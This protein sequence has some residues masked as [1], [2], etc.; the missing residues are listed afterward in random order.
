M[1]LSGVALDDY[2]SYRSVVVDLTPG[3]SVLLGRNG[4]GKT[5]FLEAIGY[6]STLHSHRVSADTALIRFPTPAEREAHEAPR[7]GV[8]RVKAHEG[9]RPLLVD[10]EIVAG[11]ANRA[12]LGRTQV[13][14][15]EIVGQIRTV[16]FAPE[17]LDVVRG[18]PSG[19]RRFLDDLVIAQAPVLAGVRAEHDKVLHQRAALLKRAAAQVKRGYA[20]DLATL[21]IWDEQLAALAARLIAARA[22]L[23]DQLGPLAERA[24]EGVSSAARRLSLG[25]EASLARY[26]PGVDLTDE[27]SVEAALHDAYQQLRDDETR[28]GVNLVGA[29]RDDLNTWLDDMPVRGFASHGETWSVALALRL[30]QFEILR[31]DGPTPILML[32]DVFAELDETRRL[33]LLSVIGEA[34]QV[35]VTAAVGQDVPAELDA[36]IYHVGLGEDGFTQIRRE[37]ADE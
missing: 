13:A 7:A 17:D 14:P 2:R 4:Q 10:V 28:R 33:A 26:V 6:L 5:N 24:H 30:A 23:V 22:R 8:I 36:T 16:L 37:G 25:Y 3:V 20:P 27:P 12:R 15:R 29:H 31:A 35:L 21:D 9:D 1:Y 32:D 19:R 11:K 34:D 18:D